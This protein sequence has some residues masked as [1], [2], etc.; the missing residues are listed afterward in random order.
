[1]NDSRQVDVLSDVLRAVRL[2]G[3]LY[4]DYEL[5]APWVAAAPAGAEVA[6]I[7]MPGVEHL[8][9]FHA[10]LA[11]QCWITPRGGSP[12]AAGPGAIVVLPRGSAHTLGSAA[13]ARARPRMNDYRR[14]A[15]CA[16]LP[17]SVKH[18]DAA[19][20]THLVCGF[21]GCDLRPFNPLLKALPEMFVIDGAVAPESSLGT[22]VRVALD[23]SR[24]QRAGAQDMVMRLSELLFTEAVRRHLDLLGEDAPGW[25]AGLRDRAVGTALSLLHGE[26]ARDWT[27]ETLAAACAVSR[28]V[29]AERFTLLVGLPP[30]QYLAMWRIQVAT[31]SLLADDRPVAQ[32]AA[33]VGY[34]SEAAFSR[35]FRKLTGQP[36]ARWRRERREFARPRAAAGTGE[37]PPAM[38]RSGRAR[39]QP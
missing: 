22:L 23:E 16:Q 34:E 17:F 19:S 32:V 3:A 30:M 7:L 12:R 25:L 8:F 28:S 6:P 1:M 20:D 13:D 39:A 15:H 21:L 33:S 9:E 36:P 37:R 11:G 26:P 10:I 35:A 2:R 4:F 14:A 38:L 29:L 5:S 31:G 18:G 24:A 27:L